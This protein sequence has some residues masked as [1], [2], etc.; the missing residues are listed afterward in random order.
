MFA[1]ARRLLLPAI[2]EHVKT[3]L[4]Q[5]PV[6]EADVT[7]QVLSD[8]LDLLFNQEQV[9]NSG[10]ENVSMLLCRMSFIFPTIFVMCVCSFILR[11][12]YSL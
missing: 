6:G 8:I 4:E 10:H 11:K 7:I 5:Q 2:L 12:S 9:R 3:L 1:E